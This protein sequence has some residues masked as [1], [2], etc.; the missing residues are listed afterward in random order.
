MSFTA[1]GS[2]GAPAGSPKP[3]E[4]FD[5]ETRE[6]L[7]KL[8]GRRTEILRSGFSLRPLAFSLLS[9]A[10]DFTSEINNRRIQRE[11]TGYGSLITDHAFKFSVTLCSN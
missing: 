8:E 6:L 7:K 10:R 4:P 2:E 1:G 5:R 3:L 9:A 11:L